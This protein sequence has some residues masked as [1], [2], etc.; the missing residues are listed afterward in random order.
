MSSFCAEIIQ[1]VL[2]FNYAP[3]AMET[4]I[5]I[6]FNRIGVSHFQS[7]KVPLSTRAALIWP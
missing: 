6:R 7:R 4:T 3:D 5:Y 1:D 2:K